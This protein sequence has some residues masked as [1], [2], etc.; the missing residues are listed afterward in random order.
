MT[1]RRK[2]KRNKRPRR[3]QKKS[4]RRQ[5]PSA[6]TLYRFTLL[7][8]ETRDLMNNTL[9]RFKPLFW[10]RD[11][12]S[13]NQ[14]RRAKTAEELLDLLPLA[15]G[16]ADS[17]WQEQM[18]RFGPEVEPLIAE[19]LKTVGRGRHKEKEDMVLEKL[20]TVLR[21]RGE[22][23]GQ[24]L[25]ENFDSLSRYGRCLACVVLGL[26]QLQVGAD[27]MW[28]FYQQVVR[29]RGDTFF[30]GALWG[31]IDLQDERAGEALVE[32]LQ[33]R[34]QFYELY[35]FLSLAG[36]ERAVLPLLHALQRMPEEARTDPTM[37]ASPQETRADREAAVEAILSK[38]ADYAR[39]H[40][41]LFYRGLTAADLDQIFSEG[42]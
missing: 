25:L 28:T 5:V 39:T 7:N 3:V 18:S 29:Q 24:V 38:P 27:K 15:T 22:T 32:L 26:L 12:G 23:G 35:G 19:R 6:A 34:R 11:G 40:F 20:T 10:L 37:A 41:Q 9:S 33:Q 42:N 36:D 14:I 17:A 31:L 1:K 30:V 21:W 8:E 13:V 2:S 4:P 16:L